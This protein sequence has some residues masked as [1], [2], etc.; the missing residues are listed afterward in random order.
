MQYW[1]GSGAV[2]NLGKAA[3]AVA[4]T[5]THVAAIVSEAGEGGSSLN[6]DIDPDDGVVAVRA[7][8]GG[9]WTNVGQAADQLLACGSVFAFVTPEAAENALPLNGDD[10]AFDRIVRIYVPAT[11]T[12]IDTGQAVTELVCND[13]IVAFRTSEVEQGYQNLLTGSGTVEDYNAIFAMQGYDLTRPECL[14]PGHPADCLVTSHRSARACNL[15]ACDPRV[16]FRLIGTRVKYIAHE[17]EQRGPLANNCEFGGADLNGDLNDGDLV[18]LVFDI[19]AGTVNLVGTVAGEDP[20]QGGETDD[21]GVTIVVTAGRCI[22]TL[23]GP[24]T[25]NAQCGSGE[26]CEDDVCKREHR[27]CN[28][29]TDCPPGIACANDD[30]D[31]PTVAASPD[32]DGDGVP[33]HTDNCVYTANPVQP[34][35]DDDGVGDACDLATCGDGVRAYD[36]VCE[37]GD[38]GQC[39]GSCT[40][41]RCTLCNNVVVDP[42]GKAQLKTKNAAGQLTAS[43]SLALGSYTAEPVSVALSDGDSPLITR[44]TLGVLPPTGKVPFKKWVRKTKLKTGVTQVQLKKAGATQPGV[45]KLSVKAK[46]WFTAG[47]ANQPAASTHL[48]VTIGTQCFRIPVTKKSD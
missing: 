26:L 3:T 22:E 15:E 25:S 10:D 28:T 48:T 12:L 31:V 38:D 1:P 5:S 35:A 42:K 16:P 7:V 45:F 17:C 32:T 33:D 40:G 27:S 11:D 23:A 29:H 18:L 21:D 46:R 47:A 19:H 34:D 14:A 36:E 20:F 9:G 39:P 8:S 6:S 44:E 41:C 37:T 24:C 43:F 30:E 13:K 2:Q 4:L